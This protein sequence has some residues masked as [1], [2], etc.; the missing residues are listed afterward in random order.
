MP[1][2]HASTLRTHSVIHYHVA[3]TINTPGGVVNWFKQFEDAA[4]KDVWP[5]SPTNEVTDLFATKMH[6][7]RAALPP[8]GHDWKGIGLCCFALR[9]GGWVLIDAP[10][11][12]QSGVPPW[13]DEA[14]GY[15]K[16]GFEGELYNLRTDLA[17]KD[18]RYGAEPAKVAELKALLAKVR[19]EG[20]VRAVVP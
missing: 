3:F 8:T 4:S 10:T 20:Q 2:V 19:A 9:H 14:N 6:E 15:A 16:N 11:G 7:A 1:P 18:N 13:F 12:A 17:Q 5:I